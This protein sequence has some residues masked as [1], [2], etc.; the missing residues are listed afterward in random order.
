M[1]L[2]IGCELHLRPSDPE[3]SEAAIVVERY[4]Q[5]EA[6]YVST[7]D[8]AALQQMNTGYPAETRML[9]ED[10]LQLGEA[11]DPDIKTKFLAFFQDSTLRVLLHDVE[12][13]YGDMDDVNEQLTSAFH[14]LRTMLPGLRIPQ[15]YAQIGSL[16]QS[17]VV[18]DG[19][20]GISLDKYLGSDYPLYIKFGYTKRQ[21]LMMTR[22]AI[23]P[24][25]LGFYLLSLYPAPSGPDASQE[26]HDLHMAHIQYVVNQAMGQRFFANDNVLRVEQREKKKKSSSM[27][28]LLLSNK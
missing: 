27:E 13:E 7:G 14:A 26:A 25:C 11:D 23:V 12:Q 16:D 20:L 17:I 22:E 2:C 6:R 1:L 19:R 5:L 24:D 4:D 18:G 10:V 15:V 8:F 21:R 3:E 9:I 28:K